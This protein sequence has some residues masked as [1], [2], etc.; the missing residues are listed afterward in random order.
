MF[1]KFHK[2]QLEQ[3]ARR[4]IIEEEIAKMWGPISVRCVLGERETQKLKEPKTQNVS[5]LGN[6]DGVAAAEEVFGI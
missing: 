6:D 3:E 2:D 1:Y 5:V 4:R